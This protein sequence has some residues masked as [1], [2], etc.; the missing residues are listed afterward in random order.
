MT[1]FQP[2]KTRTFLLAYEKKKI[3][4]SQ[5]KTILFILPVLYFTINHIKIIFF[6]FFIFTLNPDHACLRVTKNELKNDYV[7]LRERLS[8]RKRIK[9]RGKKNE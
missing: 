7:C 6:L 5:K 8:E 3:F 4:V 2:V 9:I 1:R